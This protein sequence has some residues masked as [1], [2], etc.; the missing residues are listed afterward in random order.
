ML[1][2]AILY[3]CINMLA[4]TVLLSAELNVNAEL[5]EA[6]VYLT[7][8]ELTHTAKI[9]LKS[10]TCDLIIENLASNIN[11]NSINVSLSGGVVIMSVGQRFDYLQEGENPP[12]VKKLEDSLEILNNSISEKNNEI[13]SLDAE[14]DLIMSNKVISGKDKNITAADL[15]Q[16][17]EFFHTRL[18]EIK[19]N[20]LKLSNSIKKLNDIVARI[21]NQLAEINSKKNKTVNEII[22][23]VNTNTAQSADLKLS[24]FVNNAGW[25]PLYDVRVKDIN[26][27]VEFH[28]KA[29]VWQNTGLDW[30]DVK[31]TISTR[32]PMISGNFPKLNPVHLDFADSYQR[33]QNLVGAQNTISE[34]NALSPEVINSGGGFNIRGS[35]SV[36]IQ[37]SEDDEDISNFVPG[38][39]ST[40]LLSVEFKPDLN[41][42][43][44]SD[45]KVHLVE[46]QENSIAANYEYY[47]VPKL[48][49]EAYLIAKISN[50]ES[51]NLLAGPAN[52]YFENSFIGQTRIDPDVTID[53]LTLSL[54]LDKNIII[55]RD[56]IKDFTESKFLSSDIER[57]FAYKISIKNAKKNK[58]KVNLEDLIPVS[59]NEDIQVKLIDGTGS[60]LEKETGKVKWTL[61]LEPDKSIEKKLIF[62]VRH[63]KNRKVGNF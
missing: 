17:S 24:Y 27:P 22:I 37:I 43:I 45:G 47:T 63:P 38:Q 5:T 62:S 20:K 18:L 59:R 19:N 42:T 51:I 49:T 39:T 13:Q 15:K 16:M 50:W 10:G 9:K 46:L 6:K 14:S 55:S 52:I 26:S 32:N 25:S 57:T 7:G 23:T 34:D 8:A 28:H 31:L 44:P 2:S 58:V 30:N 60:E 56:I 48:A 54:G 29:N 1:K 53:T 61:E 3:V 11:S 21:N 40:K 36:E 41:Y 33:R 35:K 12:I 4:V